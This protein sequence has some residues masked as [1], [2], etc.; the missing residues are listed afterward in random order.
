VCLVTRPG[1]VDSRAFLERH[2]ERAF[3]TH[4]RAVNLLGGRLA[5]PA[6]S[7]AVHSPTVDTV[8]HDNL[9]LVVMTNRAL[10]RLRLPAVEG[11]ATTDR[12]AARWRRE[13]QVVLDSL[14]AE[15]VDITVV[16]TGFPQLTTSITVQANRAQPVLVDLARQPTVPPVK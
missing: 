12:A 2:A 16:K 4:S 5:G 7:R 9:V 13:R 3:W 10:G 14:H 1:P 11:P 15:R 6:A 8:C